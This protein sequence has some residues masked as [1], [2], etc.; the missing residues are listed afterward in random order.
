MGGLRRN[1]LERCG[2]DTRGFVALTRAWILM[3]LRGQHYAQATATKPHY[4][5]SPLFIVVGQ[6]LTC[7]A[8]SCGFLFARVD[9]FFFAFVN[10]TLS[11]LLLG[12]AVVVE[13][14]EV[15]LNATDLAV[16]GP[17]PVSPR[18]YAAS[19]LGNLLFYFLLLFLALN[20]FPLIVGAGLRDAGPWYVPAWFASALAGNL[21]VTAL[22]VLLLSVV[23]SSEGVLI[24]KQVLS[25]LQIVAI[26]VLFY[27]GQ[28]MLRDNT[29]ALVVWGAF[30]PDWIVWLPP[31][32]LA[33]FVEKAATAPGPWLVWPF[34]LCGAVAGLSATAA[35]LRLEKL[36]RTMQPVEQAASAGRPMPTERLGGL[37]GWGDGWLTRSAEERAGFW[38]GKTFLRRDPGLTMRCLFTFQIAAA[39]A[40]VGIALGQFGNPCRETDPARTTLSLLTVFL[41]PLGAPALVYHL[42]HCRDSGGGW[43]LWTVPMRHP[44][45]FA[46]GACKA[47]QL[48][49]IT[50]LC[51]AL[52][53]TASWV[54]HDPVSGILHAAL[55]WALTWVMV[56]ASLWVLH[57]A[58]PF[59]LPPARGAGLAVPP[60]P[61]LGLGAVV[62]ALGT[63]HALAA[64]QPAYWL[65]LLVVL[66]LAGWVLRRQA[67]LRMDQLREAS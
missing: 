56:L 53:V 58:W 11:L 67:I 17:H 15:A 36:Y 45:D 55:A 40:V 4:I 49:I 3:D 34:L 1:L 20:L 6:C 54:W 27:G 18:T 25:W 41:L 44:F 65:T 30:P 2:I 33:R 51:L 39:T 19:R 62:S 7:S 28:L 9:V 14:Q 10:H 46:G 37:A 61:M 43:L 47:A 22:M 5:L 26:L 12:A 35:A 42:S 24:L 48:L 64:S 60:L 59:S 50:P 57:P 21:A 23:G 63:V 66:P 13:F 8:L 31:T 29:A 16:V 52:A 38:L 32:W